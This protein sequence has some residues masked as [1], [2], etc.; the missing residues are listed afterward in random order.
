M[1]ILYIINLFNFF[2]QKYIYILISREKNKILNKYFNFFLF[3]SISKNY[4]FSI[5]IIDKIN[6][7]KKA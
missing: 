4:Y 3:L 6:M 5:L 2:L 1:I 7:K